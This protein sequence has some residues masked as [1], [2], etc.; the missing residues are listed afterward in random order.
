MSASHATLAELFGGNRRFAIP[1]FQ[2]AYAWEQPNAGQLLSDIIARAE[3]PSAD[4]RYHLGSIRLARAPS[5]PDTCEMLS[6]VDGH[7]RIVTLTILICVLRD[8]DIAAELRLRLA[9]LVAASPGDDTCREV[10]PHRLSPQRSL[11]RII[12]MHVQESGSTLRPI[13]EADG[14]FSVS[15][16]NA[17]E[18]REHF[19]SRMSADGWTPARRGALAA[20][21]LDGCQVTC[22]IWHDEREAWRFYQLDEDTHLAFDA[23]ARVK[24]SLIEVFPEQERDEANLVWQEI[25]SILGPTE[26]YSLLGHVRT[27]RLRRRSDA[28]LA[29][30]LSRAFRLDTGGLA[31]LSGEVRTLAYRL[32]ALRRGIIGVTPAPAAVRHALVHLNLINPQA[33]IPAALHWIEMRG[34][35]DPQTTLF[36]QR[37]ER[38]IWC[39]RIAGTDPPTQATRLNRLLGEIDAGTSVAAMKE[40]E[41]PDKAIDAATVNLRSS[42]F[43]EKHYALSVLRRISVAFGDDPTDQAHASATIEHVTP[44]SPARKLGWRERRK[45]KTHLN[46]LG[47]LTLLS[48]ADNQLAGRQEFQLK[49]EILAGSA[50]AISRSAANEPDWGY[51]V[52]ARRTDD[53]IRRLFRQWDIDVRR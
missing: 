50:F 3:G 29:P 31:F 39:M 48:A 11:E 52:I 12:T 47:N 32:D 36:F 44:R 8:L 13:D 10:T 26:M 14:P 34:G 23:T 16:R 25:E 22:E 15:E 41:I 40:F 18:I 42:N 2:R 5:T 17:I 43:Y 45:H 9:G 51:D 53:L 24:A 35:D 49:R 19:L 30:D 37:L 46:M 28:P 33:W 21:L 1:W 6:I 38:V 4:R 7:Q 27:L 20:Y